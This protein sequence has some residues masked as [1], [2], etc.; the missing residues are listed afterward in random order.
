MRVFKGFRLAGV[1]L[2]AA[3]PAGAQLYV[4]GRNLPA[5]TPDWLSSLQPVPSNA[6]PAFANS[7]SAQ[8]YG[9]VPSTDFLTSFGPPLPGIPPAAPGCPST[10]LATPR[11]TSLTT[12]TSTTPPSTPSARA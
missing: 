10:S 9:I 11:I 1:L 3:L 7:Y 5:Q 12:W 4:P 6:L 2:L 8:N